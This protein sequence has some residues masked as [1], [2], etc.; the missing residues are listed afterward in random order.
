MRYKLEHTQRVIWNKCTVPVFLRKLLLP[1]H[2]ALH[3]KRKHPTHHSREAI[4]NKGRR[5]R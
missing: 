4:E 5:D 3:P 2:T 1:E